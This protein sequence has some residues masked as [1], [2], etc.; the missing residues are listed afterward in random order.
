M[1]VYSIRGCFY[2]MWNNVNVN[3]KPKVTK[4]HY[5]LIPF[6]LRLALFF[7]FPLLLL[8]PFSFKN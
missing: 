6:S 2:R 7:I 3:E 5:L 8:D 4:T 1:L